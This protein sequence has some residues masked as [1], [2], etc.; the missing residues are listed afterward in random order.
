MTTVNSFFEA[1]HIHGLAESRYAC[2]V[3]EEIRLPP[4]DWPSFYTRISTAQGRAAADEAFERWERLHRMRD[5]AA[6]IKPIAVGMQALARLGDGMVEVV[7]RGRPQGDSYPKINRH[8]EGV[9]TAILINP[10]WPI[11]PCGTLPGMDIFCRKYGS[12]QL[13]A[14]TFQVEMV[15]D[16]QGV[17]NEAQLGLVLPRRGFPGMV[18]ANEYVVLTIETSGRTNGHVFRTGGAIEDG[19]R[20]TIGAAQAAVAGSPR[21]PS[22]SKTRSSYGG[23]TIDGALGFPGACAYLADHIGLLGPYLSSLAGRLSGEHRH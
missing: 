22:L 19:V 1:I 3:D 13:R 8:S 17:R 6:A 12:L 16:R 7:S 2:Y 10:E 15:R 23:G 21:D 11:C 20:Q 18:E 5:F 9:S 14:I 4:P